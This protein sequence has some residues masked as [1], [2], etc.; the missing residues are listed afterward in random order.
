MSGTVTGNNLLVDRLNYDSPTKVWPVD[1]D[2]LRNHLQL[3]HAEDDDIVYELDLPAATAD[4]ENRG[5]IALIRQKRRQTISH[6]LLLD[7][8]SG[9]QVFLSVGPIYTLT[10][11]TY[12][13]AH[14]VETALTTD[15]YRLLANDQ[16]IYFYGDMPE[17]LD[18]PG[19]VWIDYEAGF[20]DLP[21]DIPPEWQ[22]IVAQIAFRKYDFRGGDSGQSN[23]SY[24]RMLDRMIVAA[25]GSRRG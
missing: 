15:N 20:G 6:D 23:D 12:L 10:S 18:G 2:I 24:E 21:A 14:G 9:W 1:A 7:G 25:G 22:S 13:D 11:V 5:N 16:S 19:T 3:D 4:A 8:L 17:L